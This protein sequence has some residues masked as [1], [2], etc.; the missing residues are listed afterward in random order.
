MRY[1]LFS[2][3][4][5][6][7]P[8]LAQHGHPAASYAGQE[9]RAIKALSEKEVGDLLAGAG[10]G[11]AK[12]AELNRYPGPMHALEH[13][14]ALSLTPAQREALTSLMAR[15]K[16]EARELGRELVERERHLDTLF[17]SRGADSASVDAALARIG[18]A[19]GRLRGS[20]LKTHL[21][22]T[23]ILTP[24]QVDRYVELRGYGQAGT[25]DAHGHRNKGTDH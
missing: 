9:T 25:R 23:R 22:A 3:L 6:A 4:L 16:A 5:A 10:M 17:A 12:A 11:F 19:T 20:H 18:E 14:D 13:A 21:E 2:A 15:H 8:A 1:I 24:A 7:A